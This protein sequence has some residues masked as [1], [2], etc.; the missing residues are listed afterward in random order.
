LTDTFAIETCAFVGTT[1]LHPVVVARLR[2]GFVARVLPWI[3]AATPFSG[4]VRD[5][6]IS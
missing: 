2:I 6:F 4:G 3:A 1:W 5:A